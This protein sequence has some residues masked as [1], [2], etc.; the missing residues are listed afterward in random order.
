MEIRD[1][2]YVPKNEERIYEDIEEDYENENRMQTLPDKPSVRD[3]NL[4][5]L[6]Q[7]IENKRKL[8]PQSSTSSHLK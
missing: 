1:E 6:N 8:R 5:K 2:K 4:S 3:I 7:S